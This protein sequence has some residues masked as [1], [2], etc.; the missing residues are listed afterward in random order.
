MVK[1]CISKY[2]LG[3]A[4][5]CCVMPSLVMAVY[6]MVGYGNGR[7]VSGKGTAEYCSVK[8][9]LGLVQPSVAQ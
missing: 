7:V 9:R 8:Y 3:N 1:C 2:C 6:G 4:N 5:S